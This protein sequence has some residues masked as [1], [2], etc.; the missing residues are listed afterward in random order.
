MA[1]DLE[2]E[3]LS[4][5][6]GALPGATRNRP[7]LR[8]R[9][10][11]VGTDVVLEGRALLGS[12]PD[13]DVPV[14][15]PSVSRIHCELD[16]REDG[17]WVRDLGS[18]NG[19]FVEGVLVREARLE[20][21]ATLR[22]GTTE[23]AVGY[24]PN[25]TPLQLWPLERFGPLLGRSVPMR[26]LFARLHRFAQ[27]DETVLVQ[28]ETG[29]GKELAARAIHDMSARHEAPFVV[30]DSGA[31]PESLIEAELFGHARGAFTG[32]HADRVGAAEAAHGGT[33]FLDEVGELPL[34]MQ[35]K[36]LR[37]L[38][39]RTVRRVGETAQR[40]VDVRVVAATHRDLRDMV[41]RGAFREDL[42]FRLAVLPAT[43]PP[44]RERAEDVPL[45]A[46]HFLPKGASPLSGEL[47]AELSRRPW[48][49]NVRELRNFVA[50]AVAL[51]PDEA[52]GMMEGS[53]RAGAM[54]GVDLDVPFKELREAWVSH[55]ERAYLT[56]MLARHGGNVTAVAQEARIDR[57][58]VHRLMKKHGL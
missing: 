53:S 47:V 46:S 16:P 52:L 12:A 55:L 37:F 9:S 44:L 27:S 49:G 58:Y 23:L 24:D 35:P 39:S 29:T 6:M 18:L 34:S 48:E 31:I 45:L 19:T 25:P 14:D 43:L 15:D 3:L 8:G 26:E 41:N 11:D 22:V 51:G 33:L 21:G 40:R 7:H 54:P 56:A 42:Y 1:D 50:R 38:E 57:T 28:G 2:T 13:V 4:G 32:A 5:P 30:L 36:L 10:G 17:L 20:D